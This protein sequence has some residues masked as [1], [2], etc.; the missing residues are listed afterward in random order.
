[1]TEPELR[2]K[3]ISR[4]ATLGQMNERLGSI[5]AR[6]TAI[7]GRLANKAETG[8]VLGVG[9]GLAVWVTLLIGLQTWFIR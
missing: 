8:L 6:L 2:E 3:V 5:E 9:G 7:E 1:M 4:D